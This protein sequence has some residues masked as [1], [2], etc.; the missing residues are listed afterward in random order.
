MANAITRAASVNSTEPALTARALVPSDTV[1]F[2]VDTNLLSYSEQLENAV[3]TASN[4]TVLANSETDPNG[5][6]NIA[7][8]LTATAGNGTVTQAITVAA[9][10]YTFSVYL[11]RKTGTGNID[12][13]VDGT[14][15]V[16]KSITS[17]WARYETTLTPAAGSKTPG[18]RIVTN[19]D[20]IYAWGAQLEANVAVATT[21]QRIVTPNV[22]I[23]RGIYVGTGGTATLLLDD[24]VTTCAFAGLISGTILPVR[25]TRV[26]ATGTTASNIVALF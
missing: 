22:A 20:A 11:K 16:T 7:E 3:W 15:W 9:I 21:Y 24:Q 23:A 19:T 2:S 26:N 25:C 1:K 12:I 13:S 18:I 4:V 10:P 14:T 17:S 5:I 8:T 6:P